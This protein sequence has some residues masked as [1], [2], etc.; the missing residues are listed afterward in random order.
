MLTANEFESRLRRSAQAGPWRA[1]TGVQGIYN[2]RCRFT[3]TDDRDYLEVRISV[4]TLVLTRKV[5]CSVADIV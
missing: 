4:W 5:N 2:S 1:R 3:Y